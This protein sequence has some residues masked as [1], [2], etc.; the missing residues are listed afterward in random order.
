MT[1]GDGRSAGSCEAEE[2]LALPWV[3]DYLPAGSLPG[4]K[5][6]P[7]GQIYERYGERM[8]ADLA[9][10]DVAA[11]DTAV[12]ALAHAPQSYVQP[13]HLC[14]FTGLDDIREALHRLY[15]QGLIIR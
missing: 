9:V 4:S 8:P 12:N 6:D 7:R 2:F 5:K 10:I 1:A 15:D 3:V 13:G 14:T 11:D